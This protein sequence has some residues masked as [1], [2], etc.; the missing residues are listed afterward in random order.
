MHMQGVC[1]TP[2]AHVY[3]IAGLHP[4]EI[5]EALQQF[6]NHVQ[7]TLRDAAAAVSIQ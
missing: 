4:K 3:T 7:Q 2:Q 6:R 5:I 1:V